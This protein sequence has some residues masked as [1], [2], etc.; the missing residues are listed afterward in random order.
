[1][2]IIILITILNI[3]LASADWQE[4]IRK[5]DELLDKSEYDKALQYAQQSLKF[6]ENE[7]GKESLYYAQ[8][9]SKIAE[10]YYLSSKFDDAL[11]YFTQSKNIYLAIGEGKHPGYARIIN[12]ISVILQQMGRFYEAEPYLN[13]AIAL[14]RS[15]GLTKDVSYAKSINNLAQLYIEIGKFNEAE[16][17][18]IEALEIKKNSEGT[19]NQSYGLSLLNL[20]MLY[21]KLG[22]NQK[23]SVQ[24][25]NA[26]KILKKHR[27]EYDSETEKAEL[28]LA[29]TYLALG[30]QKEAKS[31]LA[32]YSDDKAMKARL[33][34]PDYPSTL[35]N[36]ALLHWSFEESNKA[37]EL[38]NLAM[39][40]TEK[41]FGNG[42]PLFAS[43]L[44]ALGTIN[45]IEGDLT[46]A[47]QYLENCLHIRKQILGDKHPDYATTINNLAGLNKDLG[48]FDVADKLYKEA[49]SL[50]LELIDNYF[51]FLSEEEKSRFFNSFKER[52]EMFNCYVITRYE[53][54]PK[55]LND[56]FDIQLE[57]KAILINS[58]KKVRNAIQNSNNP[59][60]IAA[61]NSW[62]EKRENLARLYTLSKREI[63]SQ[64]INI[65]A[66]KD[67]ITQLEKY[68]SRNSSDFHNSYIKQKLTWKD[69][70]TKLKPDEA[71]IDIIRFR[72][73]ERG[74]S[75]EIYYAFLILTKETTQN[76]KLVLLKNGRQ[77]EELYIKNYLN[78]INLRIKDKESYKAFWEPID[79]IIQD[80]KK[81]FISPDGIYYK[82]NI[83]TLLKPD[84]SFVIDS[85]IIKILTN[86]A[87]YL[88]LSHKFDKKNKSSSLFGN[89][90]FN[91]PL[92][93]INPKL[94]EVS[95]SKVKP[96]S[97]ATLS[98]LHYTKA[99]IEKISEILNK[100]GWTVKT[101]F[102]KN[103]SENNIKSQ[104]SPNI[105][106]IATHGF[107]LSD[108]D[109]KYRKRAFGVDMELAAENPLLR[110]GLLLAGC[111]D[112]Y[113][114]GNQYYGEFENGILFANEAMNLKLDETELLVLSACETGLGEIRNGEGVYGL[115]RAFIVAGVKNL[116][117]S[118][119]K[120]DDQATYEL[121]T[122]FYNQL[123]NDKTISD[124]FAIAQKKLKENYKSPYY[125]GSFVLIGN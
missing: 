99:E 108:L 65:E 102:G 37:K 36:L 111:I 64:N 52:F 97:Q 54:N 61:Y 12:N 89:A 56:M 38:L 57:T 72:F 87:D 71:L 77:L 28:N 4:S 49:F 92:K 29:Y 30:K 115:Q 66:L 84:D 34:N 3:T 25:E 123:A 95:D 113:F 105:L 104:N 118:L 11:Q 121:M 81:I 42:H 86:S 76:P 69:I 98:E 2:K 46:K 40:L 47:K 62:L 31:I 44:N 8:S 45:W 124:A 75:D 70:Q 26:V 67:T 39:D 117:M 23:A 109:L 114:Y 103:A 32:K 1:M 96:T 73:F 116:L 19:D 22:N 58:S 83:N 93:D 9:L 51:N 53:E 50:Y 63:E 91:A 20:G 85:K 90:D 122:E 119:W 15:Q 68:L 14:K 18:L 6:A 79:R 13:E 125:W 41:N 7:F 101:Y 82:I 120:I 112:S 48:N 5:A 88:N 100:K 17:L 74:N 10:T 24:L 27:G 60:L 106:H 80:K 33:N 110:S 94:V 16:P 43:C 107:F 55:L 59:E 35:Y 21:R 78:S